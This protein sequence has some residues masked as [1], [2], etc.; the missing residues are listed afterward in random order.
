M[1]VSIVSNAALRSKVQDT[2][3]GGGYHCTFFRVNRFIHWRQQEPPANCTLYT[4]RLCG[5]PSVRLHLPVC[6]RLHSPW[7]LHVRQVA[8]TAAPRTIFF[9]SFLRMT[10]Y[11][12]VIPYGNLKPVN[13]RALSWSLCGRG[14]AI[15]EIWWGLPP[16]PASALEPYSWIADGLISTQCTHYAFWL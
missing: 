5:V 11:E 14:S 9:A 10:I 12:K 13:R 3:S 7:S 1:Q 8:P 15:S 16:C 6:F 2:I 4:A